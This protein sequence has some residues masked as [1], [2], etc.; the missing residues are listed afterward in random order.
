MEDIEREVS[1]SG[2]SFMNH[3]L[4]FDVDTK[5]EL[6]NAGQYFLL[7][8]IPLALLIHFIEN[9]M[10]ELDESKSNLNMLSEVIIHMILLFL[11]IYLVNRLI[12]YIPTYS[13]KCYTE[14]NLMMLVIG[15]LVNNS[16]IQL[17]LK[18]LTNRLEEMWNGNGEP[19]QKSNQ[20]E[21]KNVVK[22]SQP[23]TGMKQPEPTH[24]ASRAD[25][26]NQ[27]NQ[28]TATDNQ[29][30]MVMNNGSSNDM[31]DNAGFN[32]LQN[33]AVPEPEAF[34]LMGGG[35]SSF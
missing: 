21:T 11:A 2:N 3:M 32:G 20:N 29:S 14:L 34:N 1:S 35:F 26:L 8:L 16:K 19:E 28:M 24:Q 13:G 7:S 18:T 9:T 15:L 4:K 5:T 33:A 17:K 22:V 31:Y 27:H 30:N 10:P 25:Y 23:I 6:L 12:N